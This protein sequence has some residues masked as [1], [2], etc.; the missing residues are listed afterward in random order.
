MAG[1]RGPAPARLVT[2]HRNPDTGKNF[3]MTTGGRMLHIRDLTRV[4]LVKTCARSGLSIPAPRT[5]WLECSNE[6]MITL[7]ERMD[8][9]AWV[10]HEYEPEP[11]PAPEISQEIETTPRK[12]IDMATSTDMDQAL[13]VL[14][15]LLGG[16]IDPAQLEAMV[17]QAVN[18]VVARPVVVKL[19]D[20]PDVKF[21]GEL[22]HE[23]FEAL[24]RKVRA[25]VHVFLTG[26][27]GVGKTT[28]TEQ[29]ARA[30]AMEHVVATM[31]PLPQDHEFI[32]FVSPVTGKV[33]TGNVRNLYENGGI[34]VLDEFD[35]AHPSTPPTLNM[36]LAQDYFDFPG[37]DGQVE[38]VRKHKDFRVIA[39][40]NTYGG[41]GSLEFAGTTRM[42]TATMDRF[43]F[44]HVGVDEK[45]EDAICRSIH[46]VHGPAIVS[47][48]RKVRK[49]IE[50]YALKVFVTPRASIDAT[51]LMVAGDT[52]TQAFD[53]RLVGRGLPKDQESKLLEGVT[54]G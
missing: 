20:L 35:T 39:T 29:V 6:V 32:G 49:N 50:Q 53:G 28:V 31:K 10:G 52:M 47:V 54:F 34:L 40:G 38:R 7:L 26:G 14:K 16:G 3:A 30:L 44:F 13:R 2:I 27:P 23:C 42:N 22:V 36:L 25:G 1:K 9:P 17:E 46:P 51:K 43:T 41:G 8:A 15:E 48:V 37:N 21:E 19:A 4:E 12:D 18:K 33:V 24:L 45:L 5:K 11:T